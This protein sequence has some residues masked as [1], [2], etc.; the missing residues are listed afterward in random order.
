MDLTDKIKIS[1]PPDKIFEAIY[2]SELDKNKSS[3]INNQIEIDLNHNSIKN[4][5]K[6]YLL[7]PMIKPLL[8]THNVENSLFYG[9]NANNKFLSIKNNSYINFSHGIDTYIIDDL[10][11]KDFSNNKNII[12]DFK[13][14]ITGYTHEDVIIIAIKNYSGHDFFF[15][16]NKLFYSK[17]DN[18]AEIIFINNTND[19]FGKIYLINGNNE[20]FNIE[21][22]ND[23]YSIK[24]TVAM[25]I[26]TENHDNINYIKSNILQRKIN[27]L[28]GND[29]ITDMTELG[30]ILIGGSGNDII[31]AKR[32]HNIIIDGDDVMSAGD[33]NDIIISSHGNNIIS[34]GKGNNIIVINYNNN[35]TKV[36]LDEGKVKIYIQ[37]IDNIY[38]NE[39][40]DN[41]LIISSLDSSKEIT[42]YDYEKY[43]NNVEISTSL[44]NGV[45]L[46]NENIDL[47]ISA[48]S[49]FQHNNYETMIANLDN[50]DRD[51]VN[52]IYQ[53]KE[54][55]NL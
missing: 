49:A 15:Y 45:L 53:Y 8:A 9:N 16:E 29:I 47:L 37:G 46:N 33:G 42:I 20:S 30:N 41:N 2:I 54:I 40:V 7:P 1:T 21:Y 48:A 4:Y 12:F 52:Q 10:E 27:A 55:S 43:K 25:L 35:E 34:A 19:F 3:I 38:K 32:G 39:S 50:D 14:I 18:T 36:F 6:N 22:K 13:E 51:F 31:T 5:R 24:P 17:N 28:A 23:I 44:N 11:I 26:A